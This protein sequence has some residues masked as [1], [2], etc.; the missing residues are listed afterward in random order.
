VGVG[1]PHTGGLAG[2]SVGLAYLSGLRGDEVLARRGWAP[3]LAG[4]GANPLLLIADLGRPARFV[5]MVRLVKITS[6]MS[7]GS[8]ILTGSGAATTVAA[9]HSGTG[10][11]PRAP[12]V[13]RPAA[14]PLGLP[15]STY[16]GALLSST[17]VPVWHEARRLLPLVFGEGAAGGV[18]TRW[19]V[20]RPVRV[21]L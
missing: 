4:V 16:T 15:L 1:D 2:V 18:A 14:A 5:N 20:S 8:W 12:R 9:V 13:A 3:A 6:P 11:C 17:A 7:I 10:L 21:C 19:S